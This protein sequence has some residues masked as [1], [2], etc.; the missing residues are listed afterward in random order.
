MRR[1]L[2]TLLILGSAVTCVL[3]GSSR[4]ASADAKESWFEEHAAL[5]PPT[6][7]SNLEFAQAVAVSGDFMAAGGHV[8]TKPAG[9]LRSVFVYRRDEAGSWEKHQRLFIEDAG[10]FFGCCFGSEL[11][12]HA[13]PLEWVALCN[14]EYGFRPVDHFRD[15][16]ASRVGETLR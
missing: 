3:A 15:R 13:V 10:D 12:G 5:S 9:E 16:T 1:P 2:C 14:D 8:E 6:N 7:Y 11:G 4:L